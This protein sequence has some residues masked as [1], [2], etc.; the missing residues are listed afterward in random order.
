M[1]IVKVENVYVAYGPFIA[2]EDVTWSIKKPLFLSVIGP[3]GAG[4]TTLLRV[5]LGL[6]KPFVGKVEV[7]GL[8]PSKKALKLRRRIGYVPQRERIDPAALVLVKDVVL[9][10]RL[11]KKKPI[12]FFTKEDVEKAREALKLVDMDNFWDKPFSHLSGGQQQRVLIAR[13]IASQPEILLLDEPLAGV[14]IASE[15]RILQALKNLVS[16]GVT[17]VIVTHNLNPSLKLSDEVILLNRKVV[18]AGP[19]QKVLNEETLTKTFMR[20]MKILRLEK[21]KVIVEG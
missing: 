13:A 14:D 17:V 11:P 1:N 20:E 16:E 12:A 15:G 9:M 18:A 19:P 5:L 7:L 21:E 6:I 2:L 8:D 4:K 10:G 3:N